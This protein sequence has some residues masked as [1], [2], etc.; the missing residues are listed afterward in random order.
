M[1]KVR[2]IVQKEEDLES[3]LKCEGLRMI[4]KMTRLNK[5]DLGLLYGGK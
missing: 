5:R 4:D 2:E 1:G 3:W